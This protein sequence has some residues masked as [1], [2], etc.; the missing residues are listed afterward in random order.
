[1]YL[2]TGT[3][4]GIT[5]ALASSCAVMV[6]SIMSHRNLT[7]ENYRLKKLLRERSKK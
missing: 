5:I 3:L 2:D 6:I 1:M 7:K 4:I